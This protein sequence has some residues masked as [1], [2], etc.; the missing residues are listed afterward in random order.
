MLILVGKDLV[1]A[2][3]K[4]QLSSFNAGMTLLIIIW[5]FAMIRTTE[6]ARPVYGVESGQ[7]DLEGW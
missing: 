1:K 4:G 5:T 7:K 6:E 3:A 2:E